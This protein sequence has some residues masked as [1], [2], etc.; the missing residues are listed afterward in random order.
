[1][2]VAIPPGTNVPEWLLKD[3]S[4]LRDV[5]DAYARVADVFRE[6]GTTLYGTMAGLSRSLE[7][8]GEASDAARDHANKREVA[9]ESVVKIFQTASM[10]MHDAADA[11]KKAQDNLLPMCRELG[12]VLGSIKDNETTP[13]GDA[14]DE[15][16]RELT[17]RRDWLEG[18]IR[19]QLVPFQAMEDNC[20]AVLRTCAG[21]LQEL[22]QLR[23][24]ESWAISCSPAGMER[25]GLAAAME[26]LNLLADSREL[27]ALDAVSSGDAEALRNVLLSM[28][29]DEIAALAERHP[30]LALVLC[31]SM[32]KN[33]FK[34]RA[35]ADGTSESKIAAILNACETELA[36]T[37]HLWDAW[38]RLSPDEQRR[39]TL[40]YPAVFG[41]L[42]GVG[43]EDRFAANRVKVSAALHA[44]RLYLLNAQRGM[45]ERD[46]FT[47]FFLNIY[48]NEIVNEFV[49]TDSF[50]DSA[51]NGDVRHG[52]PSAVIEVSQQ[53]IDF[54]K[55]LLSGSLGKDNL[56]RNM[57]DTDVRQILVFDPRNDGRFAEVFG[58]ID[59][60]RNV[61]VFVPGTTAAMETVGLYSASKSQVALH[62]ETGKTAMIVWMDADFP[63]S[64]L[65]GAASTV[66]AANAGPRLSKF[67]TNLRDRHGYANGVGP[68][69]SVEGHS[70]GGAI[71]GVA[72]KHGMPADAIVHTESAGLSNKIFS[73]GQ[74]PTTDS[75]GNPR[76]V[77][78]YSQTAKHD[79]INVVQGVTMNM[80][81]Y[82][83]GV[84]QSVAQGYLFGVK[85]SA[86]IAKEVP[87]PL[88]KTTGHVVDFLVP[89]HTV[90]DDVAYNLGVARGI[91]KD[92]YHGGDPD[93]IKGIIKLD[94]GFYG[95]DYYD[96]DLRERHMD[97]DRNL[98]GVHIRATEYE[99]GTWRNFRDIVIGDERSLKERE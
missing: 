4:I 74:Y 75:L 98:V 61:G 26:Q 34:Q 1:M 95:K 10:E 33:D 73:T 17:D 58:N 44:E 65:D 38:G 35:W 86:K 30:A 47:R 31:G 82:P 69:I 96:Q 79:A 81:E 84:V 28:T 78:R 39:L 60:A 23:A 19:R 2:S 43:Y 77:Q 25:L 52:N 32:N 8:D 85:T 16:N 45:E 48:N 70:Y 5:A 72:D 68:R 15:L 3:T 80:V 90:L 20:A 13:R 21:Q 36:E 94:P 24:A 67:V 55:Q 97:T 57:R 29:P 89:D 76:N 99:S 91:E 12:R 18:E 53:R 11:V 56:A 87:D 41:N 14:W 62:D 63:D 88:V 49:T 66:Y 51:K 71:V 9:I 93:H 64:I 7:W 37:R 50:Y 92:P 42:D 40:T 27:S 22:C 59:T 46:P 83:V 54:Y 6:A